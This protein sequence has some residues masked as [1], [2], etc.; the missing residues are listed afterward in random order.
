VGDAAEALRG[1]YALLDAD[2]LTDVVAA[3]QIYRSA[4]VGGPEQPDYLN[5]VVVV[6]TDRRAWELLALANEIEAAHDRVR[7]ERW[8]PRTLDIDV[9]TFDEVVSNDPDLTLPHPRAHQRLFVVLPWLE[10]APANDHPQLGSLALLAVELNEQDVS[11]T[12]EVLIPND[13]APGEASS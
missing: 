12:G 7:E 11:A 3:S 5:A 9:I 10:V 4:P 6:E 1:A 13:R 2:P 8:G